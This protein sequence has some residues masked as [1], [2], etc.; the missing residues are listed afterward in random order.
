MTTPLREQINPPNPPAQSSLRV[1]TV[2]DSPPATAQTVW[3]RVFEGGDPVELPY[4]AGYV[5][6][7][8]DQVNVLLLGGATAAGIVLG[9]RAGQSGNLVV[10]GRFQ[11]APQFPQ[12]ASTDVPYHWTLWT[13]SGQ[14]AIVAG[15]YDGN[16]LRRVLLCQSLA[17][18]AGDNYVISAPFSCEPGETLFADAI[19]D[20]VTLAGG[21][22]PTTVTEEL[23]VLWF[24]SRDKAYPNVV[25]QDL[26][27]TV[28]DNADLDGVWLGG[29]ATA[30]PGATFARVAFRVT[31]SGGN[32]LYSGEIGEI[33]VQRQRQP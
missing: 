31:Q 7:P 20:F 17:G 25:S 11:E 16:G 9:G 1:G 21:L 33:S 28:S 6:V 30:P 13:A 10:N 2:L 24:D 27:A 5:P 29:S 4:L 18:G 3:V 26:I 14:A 15:S 19:S 23:L 8:G 32:L 22:G 12:P